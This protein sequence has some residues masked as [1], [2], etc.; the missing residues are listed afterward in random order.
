MPRNPDDKNRKSRAEIAAAEH[1]SHTELLAALAK[2]LHSAGLPAHRLETLLNDTARHLGTQVN[3]FALPTGVMLGV[4]PEASATTM[5]LRVEPGK[6]HLERLARLT[7]IARGVARGQIAA[8]EA[9]RRVDFVMRAP[10][11]WGVVATV[12]AYVLSA[13][14]FSVFFG[15]AIPEIVTGVC[16][17]LAVGLLAV[18]MRGLRSNTRLFELLAAVAAAAIA[19][20]A[21]TLHSD[22]VEWIPLASGL[23]ILLP[24]LA[25]VDALDELAHGN[26]ASGGARL[27][28]VGVVLLVMT[29]G[30]VV[31]ASLL[32]PAAN[33]PSAE[34][35]PG[36]PLW[37]MAPALVAVSFG[38]MIRFRARWRDF[39]EA[40]VG[41]TVALVAARW[42]T[43]EFGSFA[44]PFLAALLLGA[45]ANLTA[46]ALRQPAQLITVPGLALLVPG[47]FGVRS[48]SSLLN[49]DTALGVDT[50]FHMFLTAMAL[51]CGL[52]VSNSF[53]REKLHD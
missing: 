5:L 52:L 21:Y 27:A 11:R 29:F 8:P 16:V 22:L 30:A 25:L 40:L 10:D 47:S 24:G 14:S 35:P 34:Q 43:L 36:A 4:G 46:N 49:E 39:M 19:N 7:A 41:S 50:A 6:V 12:L 9:K 37:W 28:G 3:V 15:G 17:G 23:I 18:S 38:S 42:G 32:V 20:L 2:S 31:G 53:F 45:V 44:G 48:L 33:I 13:G 1:R 26:L 51:V